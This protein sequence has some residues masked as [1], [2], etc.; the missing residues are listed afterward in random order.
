[1]LRNVRRQI[2]AL[3]LLSTLV[4][5]VVWG[6][7]SE[8]IAQSSFEARNLM[9]KG[10]LELGGA[11]G[12]A[13]GTTVV[14]NG[15]SSNR[16]AVFVMPRVGIVLTDPLGA[17]WWQGNVEVLVQPV[18]ARFTEPFA[19]E[20]TGGSF[21]LKYNFLSFGRWVPFWDAGAGMI[22]TN[23]A[24]RI[25]EQITQVEFVMETAPECTIL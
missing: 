13:Q 24:P 14:G 3:L 17:G 23:L 22:W 15:P 9:T 19:A 4:I 2:G 21:L 18:F 8:A 6:E 7:G 5:V 16:S 10:A 25:P 12:Y 1:M 20:A 11:L